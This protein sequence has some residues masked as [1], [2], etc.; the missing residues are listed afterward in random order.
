MGKLMLREI[1]SLVFVHCDLGK[2]VDDDSHRFIRDLEGW[3]GQEIVRIRS[4]EFADI[5][6]VFEKRRYHSGMNGAPCT[7]ELKVAPRLDFQLPSDTHLW[8]Y[9]ANALDVERFA[10]MKENY[11]ELRQRSPLIERGITKAASHAMLERA[12]IKRPR[13]YDLGFPNGNCIGCVK[14]SSPAYWALV[15]KH[16]PETFARRADQCR[17]FGS[18]LVI[19]GREK[20]EDGKVKNI[21]A[22]IDEIPV[23]QPTTD[24]IVPSCDFLCAIAEQDIGE[25][26]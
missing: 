21:R 6:A 13:V 15:R 1:P 23:D 19:I 17:R 20:G 10:K 8:G 5:D 7:G 3:Y 2:S 12:G 11:P 26:A 22:F 25:A 4:S 24:P 9:T 18:R 16:Y 14:A